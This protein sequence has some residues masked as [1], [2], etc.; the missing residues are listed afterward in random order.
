M[1]QIFYYEFVGKACR[2]ILNHDG[3]PSKVLLYPDEGWA[4]T[5]PNSHL[6]LK[7]KWWNPNRC[8]IIEVSGTRRHISSKAKI[9][10]TSNG[11]MVVRG[12][13]KD[14]PDEP[15]FRLSLTSNVSMADFNQGY[16]LTGTMERASSKNSALHLTHFA[17]I[18]RK[19][20]EDDSSNK[21]PNKPIQQLKLKS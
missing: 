8:K 18:K 16:S 5:A 14:R 6:I 10:E 15:E 4:T 20:A 11:T 19:D 3:Y 17:M 2:K 7:T 21:A 9:I 12:R 13:F 1:V